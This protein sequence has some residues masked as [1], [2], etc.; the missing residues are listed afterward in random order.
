MKKNYFIGEEPE[1]EDNDIYITGPGCTSII[2]AF[3]VGGSAMGGMLW[4]GYFISQL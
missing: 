2:I 4:L 1:Q 3:L